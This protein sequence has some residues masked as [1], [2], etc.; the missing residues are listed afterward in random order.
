MDEFEGRI[1]I[2]TPGEED[3]VIKLMMRAV[4]QYI[5]EHKLDVNSLCETKLQKIL[6]ETSSDLDLPITRSWY[7]RGEYIPNP[8]IRKSNLNDYQQV[9]TSN[10]TENQRI[11]YK[12]LYKYISKNAS[13]F[14]PVEIGELLKRLYSRKAPDRY[15]RLYLSNNNLLLMNK[16]IVPALKP[17]CQ[18][19]RGVAY[20][21]YTEA[22]RN[23]LDIHTAMASLP[24]FEGIFDKYI[25][26]TDLLS[27]I[28]L[29]L[30]LL[31]ESG[32]SIPNEVKDF[33]IRL[34]DRYYS[35]VWKYP[36]LIIS[37][38]TMCGIQ[39]EEKINL[40]KLRLKS[41]STH[42]DG[43]IETIE[44]EAD[45]LNLIPTIDELEMVDTS[46]YCKEE[47]ARQ[48]LNELWKVYNKA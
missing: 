30:D 21:Y 37:K 1:E 38:N 22:S 26:I 13:E 6:C 12:I 43:M 4:A 28:Y 39:K 27:G 44:S 10:L 19:S 42:I 35:Y 36:A 25:N 9:S 16:H 20:N 15:R 5:K 24:E 31:F 29:K 11:V 17:Y 48:P 3:F 40:C 23:I 34:D 14:W 7:M 8:I 32:R 18:I 33:F 2:E 45:D 47:S 41:A 46:L